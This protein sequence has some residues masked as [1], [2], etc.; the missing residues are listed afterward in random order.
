MSHCVRQRWDFLQ[1]V[2]C[3]SYRTV[4]IEHMTPGVR[5]LVLAQNFWVPIGKGRTPGDTETVW[6]IHTKTVHRPT[7][8]MRQCYVSPA[9]E[10]AYVYHASGA[11]G[12]TETV[13][14]PSS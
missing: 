10:G 14:R 11:P 9:V 6:E 13:H 1:I 2:I 8:K 12:D 5:E 7:N 3:Y 4:Y